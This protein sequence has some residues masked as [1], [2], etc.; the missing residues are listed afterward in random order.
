MRFGES[1]IL[2]P[3]YIDIYQFRRWY[4]VHLIFLFIIHKNEKSTRAWLVPIVSKKYKS[5]TCTYC[6]EKVQQHDLYLLYW[7]SIRAWLVPIVLK[8]TCTYCIEKV[9][10]HDLYPVPIPLWNEYISSIWF[11][12]NT[13]NSRHLFNTNCKYRYVFNSFLE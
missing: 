11:H 13:P 2:G 6:I 9:Q 8:K 5:M 3:K 1:N 12:S 7:K 4:M 10:E